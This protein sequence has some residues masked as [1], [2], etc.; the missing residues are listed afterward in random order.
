MKALEE[1]L[2]PIYIGTYTQQE[3]FVDGKGE[4][5][6]VYRM[7]L[8]SG[9]LTYIS[10]VSG[11]VNPSY[12]T[13]APGYNYLYAVNEITGGTERS[14]SLSAFSVDPSTKGLTI[15][16]SKPTLGLSPCYVSIDSS[17]RFAL[18][19]NYGSGSLCVLPILADGSLGEATQ[20]VEHHGSGPNAERQEGPHAHMITP[21]P[22]GRFMIAVDLG[23]DEILVYRLDKNL[24]KLIPIETSSTHLAPGTGPRHIV[25]HPNAR[26]AY[27][28]SE[29]KSKVIA[30]EFNSESGK[31]FEK[32]TLST[33]PH[34]YTGQNQGAEIQVHPSGRFVYVSNRGHDSIV[35]YAVDKNSGE[36]SYLSHKSTQGIVPRYFCIDSTG[37][38]LLVANQDSNTI[39]TF[40]IDQDS[41]ELEWRYV[42][43][44]PTPVCIQFFQRL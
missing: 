27:V 2:I 19:A 33:L 6:Y 25:F 26:F 12:L 44:V 36:L 8:I 22:D 32:Q 38:L 13:F 14:G 35:I 18:V 5:I 24:G 29:L 23:I 30:F 15:L 28:I 10:T 34:G 20:L 7:N 4:G 1:Q 21:S 9:S 16:N 39:V 11:V 41:G 37:T 43:E 31:F 17:G 42:T 40:H 3:S